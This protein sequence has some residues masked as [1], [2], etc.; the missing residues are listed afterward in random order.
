[1]T[2]LATDS[3]TIM[4]CARN[5]RATK[6]VTG[7]PDGS[8]RVDSYD[9]GKFAAVAERQVAGIADL[10]LALDEVSLDPRCFVIRGEPL[11]G[12]NRERCRRLLYKHEDGT[13]PAF[14]EV[15]RRWAII[16]FDD[17][18][19]PYRF[20]PRDGAL[21]AIYCRSL[22]PP[23]WRR[24]SFWW[25][26][27]SS[28]GFKAGVRVKVAFWLDRAATWRE[29]ERILAGCPIDAS[30]LRPVQPIFVARPILVDVADPIR[31]RSGFEEDI[32]DAVPLPELVAEAAPAERAH[33]V[34]GRAALR[35]RRG[36][37]AAQK[38]LDA[39]CRAIERAN[40]GGRHRCL[41]W[42]AARAVELDD[43]TPA[44]RHRGR[45]DRRRSAGWVAGQRCRS[46]AAGAQRLPD[47]DL[48]RRGRSM[49][50]TGA[51]PTSR[52]PNRARTGMLATASRS[53]G[54]SRSTSL[55]TRS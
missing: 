25:A 21:A 53:S 7:L 31:Q 4:R 35:E 39:L 17:P 37:D 50:A 8:I 45:A 38:R 54:R 3:I 10:A 51:S 42:A 13:P 32:H 47:R 30:T 20:D 9:A 49:N 18:P 22:L 33:P 34:A 19:G 36:P 12:I 55:P 41:I 14:R 40:V 6:L 27:S 44:R 2:P 16:D 23:A 48:R 24:S 26:L 29:L 28:A 5:R 52:R 1:M 46:A 11:A 43:A 15:P